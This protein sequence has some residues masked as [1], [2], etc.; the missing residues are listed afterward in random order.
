MKKIILG[1]IIFLILIIVIVGVGFFAFDNLLRV[2]KYI[3]VKDIRNSKFVSAQMDIEGGCRMESKYC[4]AYF[5]YYEFKYQDIKIP[6]EVIVE[7]HFKKV[8]E[9][10]VFSVLKDK[11]LVKQPGKGDW[12]RN[13]FLVGEDDYGRFVIG[14]NSGSK[15]ITIRGEGGLANA[16]YFE[17]FLTEYI[18]NYPSEIKSN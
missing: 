8:S 11:L 9:E 5:G 13:Y 12:M 7:Q 10:N 17:D 4:F 1:L 14:W 6:I 3:A 16:D 15:L 2:E 18:G